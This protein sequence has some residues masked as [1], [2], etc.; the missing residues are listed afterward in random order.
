MPVDPGEEDDTKGA[1]TEKLSDKEIAA[2]KELPA[3]DQSIAMAQMICP[4]S[5]KH[6]GGDGCKP[7]KEVVDGKTFYL[8]CD[9]CVD[10]LKADPAKYLAKL[11]K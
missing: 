5:G 1:S 11:N 10:P 2:I 4:V 8:C 6:L 9:G 3:D 7:L